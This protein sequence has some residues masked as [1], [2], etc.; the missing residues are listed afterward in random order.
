VAAHARAKAA[1]AEHAV[2]S[3]VST[4][5]VE[6]IKSFADDLVNGTATTKQ[7]HGM[8]KLFQKLGPAGEVCWDQLK[9]FG[10]RTL[11]YIAKP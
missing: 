3:N 8:R 6:S 2:A 7:A 1:I 11:A 4:D 9:D 10:A 5:D